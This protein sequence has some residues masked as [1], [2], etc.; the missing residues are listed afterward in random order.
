MKNKIIDRLKHVGRGY[1][2][3]KL[4]TALLKAV[5]ESAIQV[6]EEEVRKAEDRAI[7]KM[8]NEKFVAKVIKTTLENRS[9]TRKKQPTGQDR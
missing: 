9:P 1:S 2:L 8:V 3:D 5:I 6:I 4:P 7:Q